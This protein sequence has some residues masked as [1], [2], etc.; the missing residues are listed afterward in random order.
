MTK[1]E[2]KKYSLTLA[3][4]GEEYTSSGSDLEKCLLKLNP[5]KFLTRGLL[6]IKSGD[7][8]VKKVMLIPQ[9]KRLFGVGGEN[10]QKIIIDGT[11]GSLQFLLG[12][13]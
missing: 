9:M 8:E 1:K 11:V 2:V 5:D 10:T 7:K 4:N 3:L 12:E 13:K 6:T